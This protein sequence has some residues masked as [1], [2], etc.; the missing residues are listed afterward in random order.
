MKC[1]HCKKLVSNL[2]LDLGFAPLSNSYLTKEVKL[3]N[4]TILKK[5]TKFVVAIPH[6]KIL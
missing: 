6:L 2:F 3:Q 1:R 5:R 4:S